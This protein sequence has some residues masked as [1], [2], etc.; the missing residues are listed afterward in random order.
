MS[1]TP[2]DPDGSGNLRVLPPPPTADTSWLTW[3]DVE[4][5]LPP[6]QYFCPA[7]K[8]VS[9]GGAPHMI[10]GSSFVGKSIV[11]QSMIMSLCTGMPLWGAYPIPRP[12]KVAHIDL[13][14]GIYRTA[15]RYQ[16]LAYAMRADRHLLVENFALKVHPRE[17]TLAN[18]NPR[19]ETAWKRAMAGRDLIVVDTLRP[20]MP[21]LDENSSLFGEG[22]YALARL[23][24]ET[25]CRAMVLHHTKKPGLDGVNRDDRKDSIRGSTSIFAACDHVLVL[26]GK[27]WEPFEVTT[28]KNRE[29]VEID[30]LFLK[31]EDVD[32]RRGLQVVTLDEE[33][34]VAERSD[35]KGTK[36][37]AADKERVKAALVAA[38]PDGLGGR[39]LRDITNLNGS[40][41][42]AALEALGEDVSTEGRKLNGAIAQVRVWVGEG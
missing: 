5:P 36:R 11:V 14:Q 42:A 4:K 19:T 37:L 21:G 29:G 2:K 30:P 26:Y 35:L 10:A 3:E 16:R 25:G 9:G 6:L 7:L 1:S 18:P 17:F 31:F 15:E 23:S 8:I 13:E 12:F 22:L 40:R 33:E 20:A 39:A 34:A 24:E 32:S 41:M 28:E 38:G 27:K